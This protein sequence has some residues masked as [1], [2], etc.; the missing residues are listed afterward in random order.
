VVFVLTGYY[1]PSLS[2]DGSRGVFKNRVEYDRKE[3]GEV[4]AKNCIMR[5]LVILNP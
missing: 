2:D 4:T 5:S 3:K 1:A